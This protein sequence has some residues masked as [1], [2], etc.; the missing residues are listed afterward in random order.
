MRHLGWVAACFG[1]LALTSAWAQSAAPG[2]GSAPPKI[3]SCT[4]PEGRRLT[5]DRPIPEC[6]GRE[7]SLHRSDGTVRAKL[8]PAQSPEEKAAEETRQRELASQRAALADAARHDRILMARFKDRSAHNLA[9]A[10][11][12]DDLDKAE[13]VTQ[14]RLADL[15]KERKTLDDEAEFY[16]KKSLPPKLKQALDTND[17]ATEAQK[18]FL[19]QQNGE[20]VRVNRRYDVELARLQKLWAGAA[21]GSLGPPPSVKD[22]EPPPPAASVSG[23]S[24]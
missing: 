4:T 2:T 18:L 3:Y 16:K 19:E 20:R 10:A 14:R 15:A 21:P 22:A 11:A 9:R 13:V 23:A 17:A 6:Q 7:Q 1:T 12:L 5:S 8:P 24:R